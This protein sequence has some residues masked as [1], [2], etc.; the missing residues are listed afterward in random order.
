MKKKIIKNLIFFCI[1]IIIINF[2]LKF[3]NYKINIKIKIE[4]II[5]YFQIKKEFK[6]NK[7]YF[8]YINNKLIIIKAFKLIKKPMVS[9]I[10]P[11]YNRGKYISKFLKIIQSQSFNFI[12]IIFIDDCSI[13]NSV[14]L[15]EEYKKKR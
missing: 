6:R 9:V 13:D 8:N 7:I 3:L 12:E 4:F 1:V 2:I 5:S 11:I 10:S 14:N 15:I